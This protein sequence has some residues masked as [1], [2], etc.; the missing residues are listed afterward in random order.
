MIDESK[1]MA[2]LSALDNALSVLGF[3]TVT[4]LL[5]A[6]P[7]KGYVKLS[8]VLGKAIGYTDFSLAPANLHYLQL[9]EALLGGRYLYALRD[10][11][12]RCFLDEGRL[13]RE[14]WGNTPSDVDMI[15]AGS[16]WK[17]DAKIVAEDC[18]LDVNCAVDKA[19]KLIWDLPPPK[20]WKPQ[21]GDDPIIKNT[22]EE[23]FRGVDL[24]PRAG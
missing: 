9:K 1:F 12:V 4:D 7:A 3:R 11:F 21:S 15:S 8:K 5:A 17:A 6:S 19:W 13:R 20:G 24:T 2:Q 14:G 18:G 16:D 22:I 23:A 10:S